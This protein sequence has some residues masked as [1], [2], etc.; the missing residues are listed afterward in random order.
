MRITPGVSRVFL[1][2]FMVPGWSR[3]Q[4]RRASGVTRDCMTVAL[5]ARACVEASLSFVGTPKVRGLVFLFRFYSRAK[6][7]GGGGHLKRLF[8]FP[9]VRSA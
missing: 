4:D 9:P 7:T 5:S 2:V 8:L 6:R 3:S 1:L